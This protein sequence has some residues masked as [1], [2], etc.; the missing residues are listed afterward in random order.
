MSPVGYKKGG[1]QLR[2]KKVDVKKL[3]LDKVLNDIHQMNMSS[4][5]PPLFNSFKHSPISKPPVG[6]SR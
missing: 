2:K 5:N 4:K 3:H 6:N 1:L